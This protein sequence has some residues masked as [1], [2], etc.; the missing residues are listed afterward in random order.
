MLWLQ[1][2]QRY[3]LLRPEPDDH[4]IRWRVGVR[5][6]TGL[7]VEGVDPT[8]RLVGGLVADELRR[9]EIEAW[10]DGDSVWDA[11]DEDSDALVEICKSMEGHD[12]LLRLDEF[13][14]S[15]DPMVYLYRFE[16]H[17]DF[18]V[19]KLPIL[20]AVCRL[21]PHDA[22]VFLPYYAAWVEMPELWRVGF[23]PWAGVGVDPNPPEGTRDERARFMI[24]DNA[25]Y[26]E[27]GP[28]EYPRECPAA[29]REHTRW[30]NVHRPWDE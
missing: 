16:L 22:I 2:R 4:V 20:D 5:A 12:D 23:R 6:E 18:T 24:R 17:P 27:F 8:S 11:A 13:K 15:A 9:N 28:H 30:L 29:T 10:G 25:A 1:A 21:F 3:H 7:G 14:G 26:Q 19:W